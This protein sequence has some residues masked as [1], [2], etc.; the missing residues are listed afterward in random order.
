MHSEHPA[1]VREQRLHLRT[2]AIDLLAIEQP[3]DD[4]IAMLVHLPHDRLDSVHVDLADQLDESRRTVCGR[5]R[6]LTVGRNTRSCVFECPNPLTKFRITILCAPI[7]IS[8]E[9][10]PPQRVHLRAKVLDRII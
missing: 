8:F 10:A 5:P 9:L 4:D 2:Y 6:H 7:Q 1:R 3:R